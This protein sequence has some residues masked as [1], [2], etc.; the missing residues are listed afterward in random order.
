ANRTFLKILFARG[1]LPPRKLGTFLPEEGFLAS[2]LL[3]KLTKLNFLTDFFDKLSL[4]Q[5]KANRNCAFRA[6][7]D[8]LPNHSFA[9]S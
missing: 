6:S 1:L 4:P 8:V 7:R 2:H 5:G 3:A 9:H